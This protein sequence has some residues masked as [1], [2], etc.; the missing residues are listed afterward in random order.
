MNLI[1]HH[2]LAGLVDDSGEVPQPMDMTEEEKDNLCSA[3]INTPEGCELLDQFFADG[4]GK[5]IY[6]KSVSAEDRI[7][8]LRNSIYAALESELA[9]E[10]DI[11]NSDV[12]RSCD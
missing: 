4:H 2:Y 12:V 9:E 3:A 10:I 6:D 7:N 1:P 11:Y 8:D 5:I